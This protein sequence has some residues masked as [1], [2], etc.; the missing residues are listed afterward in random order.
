MDCGE[1]G[2]SQRRIQEGYYTRSGKDRSLDFEGIHKKER[3]LVNKI[4]RVC[5]EIGHGNRGNITRVI[6]SLGRWA[7]L[8]LHRKVRM[9]DNVHSLLEGPLRSIRRV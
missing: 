7:E 9:M 6:A 1:M 4:D 8:P 3:Y 5:L 2:Q